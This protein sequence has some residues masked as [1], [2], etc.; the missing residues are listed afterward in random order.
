[1][2]ACQTV[3]K[4]LR[5]SKL[6]PEEDQPHLAEIELRKDAGGGVFL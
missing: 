3:Q 5:E 1:M 6:I 4:P 2:S